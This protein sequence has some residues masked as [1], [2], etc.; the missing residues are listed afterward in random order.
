V[1]WDEMESP[2]RVEGDEFQY[3]LEGDFEV[4]AGMWQ[5]AYANI[6]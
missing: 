5:V 6:L 3:M 4:G 2:S 1:L